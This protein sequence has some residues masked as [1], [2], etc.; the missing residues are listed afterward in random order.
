[1][2]LAWAVPVAIGTTRLR[3][4]KPAEQGLASLVA[5]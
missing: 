5:P 2:P 4:K 3:L 1:M